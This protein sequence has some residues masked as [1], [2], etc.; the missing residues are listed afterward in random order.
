MSRIA[1]WCV[2]CVFMCT[3]GSWGQVSLKFF[4]MH[5]NHRE[6][7]GWPAVRFGTYRLWDS[8]TNWNQISPEK[9]VYDWSILDRRLKDAQEHGVDVLYTFGK[10]PRW[11]SSHPDDHQQCGDTPGSC[12]PPSDLKEDGSGSDQ[13]WKDFVSAIAKHAAGRI[14]AWELWNEPFN[15]GM[16]KGTSAQLVRM[17]QDARTIIK[18]VDPNA[19]MVTPPSG[20]KVER[21]K[22]WLHEYLAAGGGQY[23]D[24][25]SYHAYIP[26]PENIVPLLSE[27]KQT[28]QQFGLSSK[29][30]WDSEGSWGPTGEGQDPPADISRLLI[31]QAAEGISRVMWYSW[32]NRK[33]GNLWNQEEGV[34]PAA[35]AYEQLEDWLIGATFDHPCEEKEGT[36]TC[37]LHKGDAGSRARIVWFANPGSNATY[38]VP[39]GYVTQRDLTGNV[40][41]LKGGNVSIS[42]RPILLE[43]AHK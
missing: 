36:W 5:V 35:K 37:D 13:Y 42:N 41:A 11:A 32:D 4:G 7:H 31:L 6:E 14:Q 26:V 29:P 25:I 43:Q 40:T 15:K 28:L 1:S 21:G 16:W 9:G 20:I 39:D 10:T 8:Q 3:A 12:W 33:L 22:A 19:I 18:G 2:V 38:K 23:A 27:L 30:I 24:A 17:A 34:K